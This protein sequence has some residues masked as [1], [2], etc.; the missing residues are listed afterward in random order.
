MSYADPY[1]PRFVVERHVHSQ[2][3]VTMQNHAPARRRLNRA[4]ACDV[5]IVYREAQVIAIALF[6]ACRRATPAASCA[7]KTRASCT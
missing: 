5:G 7:A 4:Y 3:T 1:A 6:A 2:H